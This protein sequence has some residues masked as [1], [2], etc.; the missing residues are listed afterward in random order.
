MA[1]IAPVSLTVRRNSRDLSSVCISARSSA[2]FWYTPTMSAFVAKSFQ[3]M[4]PMRAVYTMK[5]F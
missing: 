4:V 3:V 5:R 1:I 2:I